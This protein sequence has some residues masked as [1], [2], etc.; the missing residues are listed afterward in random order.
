[1]EIRPG[2]RI[3]SVSILLDAADVS[4]RLDR[5]MINTRNFCSLVLLMIHWKR[6]N[7]CYE[8][9]MKETG[10]SASIDEEAERDPD[11]VATADLDRAR[12]AVDRRSL[13]VSVDLAVH[14]QSVD[15]LDRRYLSDLVVAPRNVDQTTDQEAAV[16]PSAGTL[17]VIKERVTRYSRDVVWQFFKR[18]IRVAD[19]DRIPAVSRQGYPRRETGIVKEIGNGRETGKEIATVIVIVTEIASEIEIANYYLDIAHQ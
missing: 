4:L 14:R 10:A 15:L 16:S 3:F 5:V 13:L 17:M 2:K 11:L 1:M 7:V 18:H 9:R 6:S 12:L 19:P 8:R